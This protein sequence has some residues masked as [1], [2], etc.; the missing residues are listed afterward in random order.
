MDHTYVDENQVAERYLMGKLQPAEAALFEEHSLGCQE[1]LDRLEAAEELRLGLRQVATREAARAALQAGVL[2]W[3]ARL[4]RSRQVGLALAGMAALLVVLVL[5]AGLLMRRVGQLGDELD[6]TRKE[7]ARQ[8]SAAASPPGP[9]A[10][11]VTSEHPPGTTPGTSTPP[12]GRI[13][14]PSDAERRRLAA[15]LAAERQRSQQLVRKLT[16]MSLPQLNIPILVLGP[17][18]ST[19][20]G[21]EP[22]ARLDLAP[23]TA[24]VAFSLE[25]PEA[26]YQAYHVVLLGPDGVPLWEGLGLTADAAGSLSLS[27]PTTLL[28]AGDL[29]LRVAGI[30]AAGESVP[31]A[32][33]AFRVLHS[34]AAGRPR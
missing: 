18:R 10:G 28:A 24:R 8:G 1:C 14:T 11:A 20:A 23:G 22:T 7:L 15:E 9:A 21:A 5:P 34:P 19:T 16:R 29:R 26:A 2:A 33:Y 17:E 32:V 13:D 3:L 31:V 4:A 27:L 25:L 12:A 6:R 30:P